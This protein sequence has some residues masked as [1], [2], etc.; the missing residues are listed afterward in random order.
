MKTLRRLLCLLLSVGLCACASSPPLRYYALDDGRPM[1]AGMPNGVSVAIMQVNLPELV[2]RPQL[3]LRSD[4][5]RVQLS[6]NDR[7]VEP[8]RRQVPRLLARDLGVA[9]DSGRVVALGVDTREFEIDFK[10]VVDVQ[11]LEVVLGQRVE[12]DAVWRIVR[13]NTRPVFGRSQLVQEI[14]DTATSGDYA[15]AVNAERIAFGT[16][17]KNIATKISAR[18]VAVD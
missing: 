13:R 11:H 12:L 6:E 8:L 4:G 3:V 9:L 18:L 14:G 16:L 1:A 15:A 10:V 2:D 17:A 7:W 5:H